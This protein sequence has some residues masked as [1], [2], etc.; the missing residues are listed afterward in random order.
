MK[1][2]TKGIY[3]LE[4]AVDLAIHSDAEHL[5]S[6]KNI[7]GRR[8]LSEKYLERIISM[9]KKVNLV[10]STRGAR[11][12][13]CLAKP[14]DEIM[15]YDIL[16]AVEGNLAPV[17]C[18]IKSTDCG[19]DCEKCPTRRVWNQMWELIKDAAKE[20]RLEDLLNKANTLSSH[21]L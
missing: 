11:G 18:L 5:E 15:V 6:I 4:I 14:A 17:E 8:N 7:A 13:Y 10:S 2:S 20:T 3:A 1:I 21:T 16:T 19:I 12:G 9:L